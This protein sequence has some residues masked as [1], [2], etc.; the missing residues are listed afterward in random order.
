MN[1]SESM[2]SGA[3]CAVTVVIIPRTCDPSLLKKKCPLVVGLCKREEVLPLIFL[4][5]LPL[6]I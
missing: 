3:K 2:P 5:E 1:H 4:L 6:K